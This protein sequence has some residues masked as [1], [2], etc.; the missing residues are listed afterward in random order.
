MGK[1]AMT[2]VKTRQNTNAS[3]KRRRIRGTSIQ[4]LERSTSFFVAPH[5]MLY[6]N[7]CDRRACERWM[8]SPPKKKKLQ[9]KVSRST[10]GTS[11]RINTYKNGTQVKFS[12]SPPKRPRWPRRYWSR[13]KPKFPA[14]G[15]T[16]MHASHI[17]KLRR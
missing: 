17:S 2:A 10:G 16:T 5:V 1:I 13:V 4:K 9:Q 3:Q 6:E 11:G 8:L 14:P 12:A 7:R 15:N